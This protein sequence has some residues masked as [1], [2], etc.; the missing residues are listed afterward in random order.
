MNIHE[1]AA[2]L[3]G[4]QY[5]EE[6]SRELFA[7][8]KDAGLVAVFGGSDDLM[9]FRGAIHDETGSRAYI[10]KDGLLENQCGNE[11]CP[12]YAKAKA[13]A[14][15]IEA[16]WNVGGFSWRYRTQ[17]PHETFIIKE[18]EDN[19]CEGIVFALANVGA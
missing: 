17:I 14:A 8:M 11:R 16:L 12:Y 6:G 15:A 13:S 9:E 18:D 5:G 10:T 7:A 3:D 4:N 1:A 19:Y 2:Q